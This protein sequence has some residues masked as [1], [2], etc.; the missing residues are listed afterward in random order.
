M[1][2]SAQARFAAASLAH[3]A[4]V[5]GGS[6]LT[7]PLP[8]GADIAALCAHALTT[9]SEVLAHEVREQ[10]FPLPDAVMPR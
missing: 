1:A 8:R 7:D 4:E 6:F 10:P 3:R 9:S 5:V 2:V